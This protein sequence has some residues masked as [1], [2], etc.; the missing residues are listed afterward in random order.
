MT[1]PG[2]LSKLLSLG[3]LTRKRLVLAS[4]GQDPIV[5]EV[6]GHISALEQYL[7]VTRKERDAL[8]A[9]FTRLLGEVQDG[10]LVPDLYRTNAGR[11]TAGAVS[12]ALAV[13]TTAIMRLSAA[14]DEAL[15]DKAA[16]M[17]AL[18]GVVACP[19]RRSYGGGAAHAK[20]AEVCRQPHPGVVLLETHRVEVET[21]KADNA[22]LV[23]KV[24][25]LSVLLA[26]HSRHPISYRDVEKATREELKGHPGAALLE[27]LQ[28]AVDRDT[29]EARAADAYQR[30]KDVEP[31][32]V[33]AMVIQMLLN[34]RW[35]TC[36]GCPRDADGRPH[37]ERCVNTD[38]YD[39]DIPVRT[40]G[41]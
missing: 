36:S 19:D 7:E 1:E 4:A 5:A 18:S 14:R 13:K 15:A 20:A 37:P 16:F 25:S 17:L 34:G 11:S 24:V 3:D 26:A 40:K 2:L 27:Q 28:K 41:K 33:A 9:D 38:R 22:A 23:E 30:A 12:S 6:F 39:H 29:L 8:E 21:L 32:Y 31:R 10:S 35:G